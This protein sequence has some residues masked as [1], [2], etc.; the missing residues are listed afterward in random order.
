MERENQC[1]GSGV[2]Q[3]RNPIK[4]TIADEWRVI[5]VRVAIVIALFAL[6]LV[7]RAR[8]NELEAI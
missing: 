5:M 2:R 7:W 1:A 4:Q 8:I 3:S 6:A